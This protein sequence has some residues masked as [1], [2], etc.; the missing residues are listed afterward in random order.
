[1]KKIYVKFGKQE[2]IRFFLVKLFGYDNRG[3]YKSVETYSDPE[4]TIVQCPQNKY[5][6]IED[7]HN[8]VNTYY[9]GTTFKKLFHYLIMV[10][11]NNSRAF[12]IRCS[13]INKTTF[14]YT[15]C[16]TNFVYKDSDCRKQKSIY[17]PRDCYHLL[18]I[19]SG[20]KLTKYYKNQFNRY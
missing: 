4:C 20:E 10:N 19:N 17:S 11:K 6:S 12:F 1:M 15:R 7:I 8:I 5:R 2:H 13:D 18:G 3:Q 14:C 9:P 16:D